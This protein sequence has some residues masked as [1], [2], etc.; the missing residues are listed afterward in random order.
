M[1]SHYHAVS[2]AKKWG[3]DAD[4]YL[5]I[6]EFIDGSK[7][8]IADIRHRS[9]YH[10]TEGVWLCRHLFGSTITTSC[11]RAV[12]VRL[13]AER[14]IIEDVGYLPT[15]ADYIDAMAIRP[16]MSGA[17]RTETRPLS[18]LNLTGDTP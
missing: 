13:I 9:L 16:W 6:H 2:S 18:T 17:R 4:D 11:G 7:R 3:G 8:S 1:N 5:A 14:H 10:H 15:P 12:P